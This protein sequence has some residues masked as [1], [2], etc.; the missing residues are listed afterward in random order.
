MK[1]YTFVKSKKKN[2]KYD[3]FSKDGEY[4][5]SFGD[6]RYAQYRDKIGEYSHL[7]HNNKK[8]KDNYYSRFGKDA[9]KDTAKYFSHKFLW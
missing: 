2:K 3:A 1:D 5:T 9:K 6:K 8:R 7:N 4:I